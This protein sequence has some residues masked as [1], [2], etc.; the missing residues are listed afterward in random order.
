MTDPVGRRKWLRGLLPVAA[1]AV[2]QMAEVRGGEPPPRRRPPGAA[3]ER[4][5]LNLCT[6]CGDCVEACPQNAIFTFEEE[7]GSLAKTP[8][9][10]PEQRACVMCEGFPCAAACDEG[11]LTPPETVNWPLGKVSLNESACFA[12]QG[13]ECGACADLCPNGIRGIYMEMFRPKV[14]R[15]ECV[16]CGRCIVACPTQ[17]KAIEL[18]PL[19]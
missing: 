18:Q 8:L 2:Q 17:P 9:L 1:E 10:L 19:E 14:D 3:P 15:D 13:P 4:L 6:G 11:A 16:G 5:F 12:Y 7:A